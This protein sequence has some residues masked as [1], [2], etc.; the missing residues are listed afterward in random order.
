M[1]WYGVQHAEGPTR[2]RRGKADIG[3][4]ADLCGPPTTGTEDQ[5]MVCYS[6]RLGF[7][8]HDSDI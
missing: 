8:Q 6:S 3:T 1:R 5:S 4:T 2:L 7:D